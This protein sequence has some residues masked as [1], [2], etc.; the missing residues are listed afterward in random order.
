[1]KGNAADGDEKA[2]P[3]V[4]WVPAAAPILKQRLEFSNQSVI[5]Q[6]LYDCIGET[7]SQ[8]LINF[9]KYSSGNIQTTL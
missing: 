2:H 7:E 9:V 8:T 1:L 4:Q 6:N 5:V 3:T